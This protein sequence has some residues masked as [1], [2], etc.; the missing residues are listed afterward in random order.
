ML[1]QL[2]KCN[3]SHIYKYIFWYWNVTSAFRGRV[4]RGVYNPMHLTAQWQPKKDYYGTYACWGI[5]VSAAK[6]W[7]N[8]TRS[9]P[10]FQTFCSVQTSALY[11]VLFERAYRRMH[12]ILRSRF[13]AWKFCLLSGILTKRKF[14]NFKFGKLP[15]HCIF[16]L[17]MY[18]VCA[19]I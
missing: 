16:H 18:E 19:A 14:G 4:F 8:Y 17:H 13:S 11:S 9:L 1:L 10:K 5:K 3:S 15:R 7:W 6:V 2:S 12:R